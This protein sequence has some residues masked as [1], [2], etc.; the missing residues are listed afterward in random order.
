MVLEIGYQLMSQTGMYRHFRGTSSHGEPHEGTDQSQKD[1]AQ[2][3]G[4]AW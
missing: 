3:N 4:A 1:D 2:G